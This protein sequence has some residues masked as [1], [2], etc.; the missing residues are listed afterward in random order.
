[1]TRK[2]QTSYK[3]GRLGGG[4][5]GVGLTGLQTIPSV[6]ENV[7]AIIDSVVSMLKK[8]G[9]CHKCNTYTEILEVNNDLET[10]LPTCPVQK[11]GV[12]LS[13]W[14]MELVS[15]VLQCCY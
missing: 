12:F 11:T 14:N 9:Q 15:G 2:V 4:R 3:Q 8:N 7:N 10:T 6:G 1:M 13:S 5:G